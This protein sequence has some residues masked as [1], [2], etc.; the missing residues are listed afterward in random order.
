MAEDLALRGLSASTRESYLRFTTKF[1]A[2]H[3]RSPRELGTEHVRAW[4]LHLLH[5]KGRNPRTVNVYIAALRFL[6]TVTLLRP[7]GDGLDSHGP[8]QPSPARGA[9]RQ[10]GR[11]DP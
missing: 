4:I 11:G 6:F 7:G 1:V 5:E 10:R 2:F 9:R 3:M 8:H